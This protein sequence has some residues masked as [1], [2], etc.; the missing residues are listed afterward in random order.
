MQVV[1]LVD[2]SGS[3]SD[4]DVARER[5]AARTIA[6]SV[7]A[8]GSNLSVVGFGSSNGQGQS[9]V[10]VVCPPTVLSAAQ[11]RDAL[12]NCISGLER[13]R[14]EQG[15][16]TD[17]AAAV[18]QALAFI[19]AGDPAAKKI[20]FL[21]TDGVLDVANSPAYGDTPERRNAAARGNLER[22]LGQLDAADAQ[23]W[24]LGFGSVDQAALRG[25][26]RGKSCTAAARN[27]EA[28]VVTDS[29]KLTAAVTEAFSSA[30]CVKYN[31]P[32]V[33]DVSR[34]D[35]T[36]L[37]GVIPAI[38]SEA[39][40][41]VYKRDRRV[42][43]EYVAPDADKPAPEEGGS[44]FEFAGQSTDVET[45]KISDPAPGRWTI[46][47]SS[48]DVAAEDVTATV[49]YQAAVRTYLTVN[50]PQPAPGQDVTVEMQ[51][52]ARNRAI[53]DTAALKGLSFVATMSGGGSGDRQVSLADSDADGT[54]TGTVKLPETAKGDLTFT[55]QVTGIGIGGDTRVLNTRVQSAGRTVQ[56]AI[57]FDVNRATAHPGSELPGRISVRNDAATPVRLRLVVADPSRGTELVAD[58]PVI[59]VATGSSTT[60]FTLRVGADSVEGTGSATLRLV[61]EASPSD[62]VAERLF[63]VGISPVPSWWFRYRWALLAVAA[64]LVIVLAVLVFRLRSWNDARKVRGLTVRLFAGGALSDEMPAGDP[65][66]KVLRFTV[67][68]DFSGPHLQPAT[69]GDPEA[70]EVRREGTALVL[71]A[72]GTARA[73]LATGVQRRIGKD[74]SIAVADATDATD[75]GTDPIGSYDPF[76]GAPPTAAVPDQRTF[77]PAQDPFDQVSHDPFGA[78]PDPRGPSAATADRYGAS[79]PPAQPADGGTFEDLN[80]PFR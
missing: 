12:A 39:S 46:R 31:A 48:A 76:H 26:A 58:P 33:G 75:A 9:A 14:P 57:L 16:D 1:V 24:P 41:L 66:G 18:Q 80:N 35:S 20:V 69:A 22:V 67:H 43:V 70:Y 27:P 3:L 17:H 64:L 68:Q 78:P 62:V 52:W 42:Q 11:D 49:V 56:G 63:A 15:A 5:D 40:I 32:D 51:V 8:P 7:L 55:G 73:P 50:P 28:R 19:R 25:F 29:S 34:G 6:F 45:V 72:P 47:L 79:P 77:P 23:V 21:L 60:P 59:E 65:N 74:L 71:T 4:A 2:E 61:D 53:A 44:R 13:R 38:A 10:D 37:H 30:G 36:E 54:Y